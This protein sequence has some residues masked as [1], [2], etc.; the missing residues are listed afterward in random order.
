[1]KDPQLRHCSQAARGVW[2]DVICLAFECEERGVL[3][4]G[5]IAWTDQEIAFA[6]PGDQQVTLSCIAEL[7]RKGVCSRSK[8]GAI[9]CRRLVRDE[10]VRRQTKQRV[11]RHRNGDVTHDVTHLKQ[12]SSSSSSTSN[13]NTKPAQTQ[14]GDHTPEQIMKIEAKQKRRKVEEDFKAEAQI[15]SNAPF[16]PNITSMS[17]VEWEAHLD[18]L[19]PKRKCEMREQ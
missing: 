11:E 2:M 10:E 17:D 9:L 13:T 6:I 3:A 12:H 1:M 18:R 19:D 7:L 5:G 14:R 4:T 15:G 8:T 16:H